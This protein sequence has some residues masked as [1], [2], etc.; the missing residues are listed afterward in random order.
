[1]TKKKKRKEKKTQSLGNE[2]FICPQNNLQRET[3]VSSVTSA[4]MYFHNFSMS[5]FYPPRE[6]DHWVLIRLSVITPDRM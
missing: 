3:E 1:M 2:T 5:N 4:C 6:V